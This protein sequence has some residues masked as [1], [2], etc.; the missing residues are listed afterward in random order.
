MANLLVDF[1]SLFG[2]SDSSSSQ[3]T[4]TYKDVKAFS[5]I[6]T[7]TIGSNIDA[8]A[9]AGA[10]RNILEFKKGQRPLDPNFGNPL[11]HYIYEP[12]SDQTLSSIKTAISHCLINYEPRINIINIDVISDSTM[13][14]NH[15]IT[16]NIVYVVRGFNT[17]STYSLTVGL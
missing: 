14:D 4:Y 7:N 17:P 12:I 9:V 16:I 1:S 13:R 6:T 11:Y 8:H 10:I 2:A 15:E 3:K 5:N